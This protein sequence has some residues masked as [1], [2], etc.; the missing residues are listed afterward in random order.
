MI[1]LISSQPNIRYF[2]GFTGS[3]GILI[4][5]ERSSSLIV[6]GRY[7]QQA[8]AEV[9][10]ST[11]V[12]QAPHGSTIWDLAID[13]LSKKKII[14]LGYDE[15]KFDVALFNK[16]RKRMPKLELHS[17]SREIRE[18]RAVK[19]ES[20]VELIAKAALIADLTFDCIVHII[21]PGMTEQEISAHIDYLIKTF[22][23][24][25]P[26]FETLVSS[27]KLSAYPHGKPSDK[28]VKAGELIILD[29]GA[30]YKGYN[31]DI[32]RMVSIG[33]PSKKQSSAYNAVLKAQQA[34]ISKIKDGVSADLIDSAAR[35][36][37]KKEKLGKYFV[38]GTGHGVGL[39]V[40]EAPRVSNKSKDVLKEGMVI[41]VEPGVYLHGFGGFRVEDMVLVKKS[42]YELLTKSPRELKVII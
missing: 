34:A 39:Q 4:I 12:L 21:R 11:K 33:E 30:R 2:S 25:Y 22:K 9:N 19:N 31:S 42:G 7:T 13:H 8:K 10:R 17:I 37:L 41:T 38:H 40:H 29:F 20:E 27:G 35:D 28:Q 24:E 14:A 3:V 16:I 32:T 1:K 23:G 18:K 5:E 6:D 36:V 26:A 15:E